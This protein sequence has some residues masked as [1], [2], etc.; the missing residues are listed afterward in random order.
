MK[1]TKFTVFEGENRV[2]M[3]NH[4]LG[5]F[6]L[7]DIPPLPANQVQF[8]VAFEIDGNGILKDTAVDSFTQNQKSI[9]I[10]YGKGRLAGVETRN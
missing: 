2:A 8:D 3:E 9:E 5:S 4:L 10:N 1:R 6:V 7:T